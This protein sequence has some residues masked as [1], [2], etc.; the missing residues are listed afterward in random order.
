[1]IPE[2]IK[3]LF[4]DPREDNM[5]G[6]IIHMLKDTDYYMIDSSNCT[7]SMWREITWRRQGDKKEISRTVTFEDV[8]DNIPE[9]IQTHLL[10]HLDF[11]TK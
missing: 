8:L 7:M 6:C 11:F 2:D 5:C 4:E 9:H 3:Y 1:M 10:F